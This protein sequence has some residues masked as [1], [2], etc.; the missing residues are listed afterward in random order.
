MSQYKI[1]ALKYAGPVNSS[2]AFLMWMKDWEK[3]VERDYYLWCLKSSEETI[4]VDTGVSPDLNKEKNINGYVDP[5]EI[6]AQIDV[7]S[8]EVKHVVLTHIHWDHAGG[9]SLFPGAQVYVQEKEYD[10]WLNSPMAARPPFK[11]FSDETI[12][13]NLKSLRKSM[14]LTLLRGDQ[15]ILPGIEC[16]LAPGHSMALQAVAVD[17]LKGTAIVGSDSA[18]VFRNFQEDWPSSVCIDLVAWLQTYDKLRTRVSSPELFFP[19]HDATMAK[20]YPEVAPGVTQLV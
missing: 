12:N 20:N 2:G 15:K 6:L 9:L 19:G 8:D 18:H 11:F 1:Y 16:L 13:V 4:I 3:R 7:K 17:T 10:F 14:R 5:R